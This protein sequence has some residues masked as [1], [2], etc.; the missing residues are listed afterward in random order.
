MEFLQILDAHVEPGA[1][2][3]WIPA[4]A[5]GMGAW[6]RDPRQTS[7][8]HEQHLR[9]ALDY[10][11][12]T[13]REGGREAWLGVSVDFDEQI[14]LPAVRKAIL[15]WI[16]RHEVLRTH[17]ALTDEG[18][19]RYTTEPGA[20]HLR[21][22]RVGWYSDPVLLI[23]QIA[24]SFDRATAPL[25]WPAYRFA[26]VARAH[27]FTLLFAADHSLVDGYSLVNAHGELRE[28]Y[29]AEVAGRAP[30]LPPTG[31]YVDFSGGERLAADAADD[32]H[33]AAAE[34]RE[35]LDGRPELPGFALVPAQRGPVAPEHPPPP[36]QP[37]YNDL[38]L[39]DDATRSLEQRCADLGGSL[40]GG[41]LAVTALTYRRHSGA[42]RFA[43]VMPRHTR[44]QAA[45]HSSLGWFVALAPVFLDISDDPDFVQALE[46]VM[47]SLDRA[48]E[49]ASLPI[50]RVAEL[51]SFPPDPKFVVSFMDT[52]ALPHA[53]LADAGGAH[54]L[55]SHTYSED[56][57]YVWFTR[58]PGGL[59]IHARFP[60]DTP[61]HPTATVLQA[62]FADFTQLLASIAAG[63]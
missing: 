16:D 31:S 63:G 38:L 22:A 1:L 42:T 7:H 19:D 53:E 15:A 45:Y 39:D 13:Q 55:R 47:I 2:V 51:L 57:V 10:R 33:T 28:L 25:H 41:L 26:T 21:D 20:V 30:R 29:S 60:A 49:G 24:G 56:E 40:I 58:T 6:R 43:T 44:T 36:A 8:N 59:R 18:T 62:F 32:R 50:R 4:A 9:S 54:A 14:S 11:L 23:E 17:V 35:F 34:W 37:S 27:S 5:G 12:R 52:R 46:R 48:R 61:G 3:E